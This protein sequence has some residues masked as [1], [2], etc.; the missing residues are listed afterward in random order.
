MSGHGPRRQGAERAG[1]LVLDAQAG[2]DLFVVVKLDV[3]LVFVESS[4]YLPAWTG[5]KDA[6]L[7]VAPAEIV[8]G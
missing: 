3:A 7:V 2:A 8:I 1:R 4:V 6:A 5:C